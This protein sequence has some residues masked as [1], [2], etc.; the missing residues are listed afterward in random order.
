MAKNFVS[1][2]AVLVSTVNAVAPSGT[3]LNVMLGDPNNFGADKDECPLRAD[4]G[5][6]FQQDLTLTYSGTEA[7]DEDFKIYLPCIH[8]IL[9][10]SDD[11]VVENIVGDLTTITPPKDFKFAADSAVTLKLTVEYW[12]VVQTDNMPRWFVVS[13]GKAEV[14]ANTDSEDITDFSVPISSTMKTPGDLNV[15]MNAESRFDRNVGHFGTKEAQALLQDSRNRVVPKP[16]KT[17]VLSDVNVVLKTTTSDYAL[18]IV[19]A[20]KLKHLQSGAEYLLK[21][22]HVDLDGTHEVRLSIVASIEGDEAYEVEV[23]ADSTTVKASTEKGLFYGIMTILNLLEDGELPHVKITD[24][25]RFEYRGNHLDVGRNFYSKDAILKVLDAMAAY[26]LNK[27]H[28]GLTNDEAWRLQIPDLPELTD[29]GAKR[30]FEETEG[31]T[32]LIPT[33]GSGPTAIDAQYYTTSDYKEILK[34]A[35]ARNIEVIPEIDMPAHMRAAVISMES[36]FATT[37]DDTYRLLDPEDTTVLLTIQFYDRTSIM[38][39]CLNSSKAFTSKVMDEVL[40]MYDDAGIPLKKWHFG[41]D[42]AK[43]ILLGGG[44]AKFDPPGGKDKPFEKSPACAAEGV[45]YDYDKDSVANYWGQFV[46]D[47]LLAHGVNEMFAWED[48]VRGT[49]QGNYSTQVSIDFWEP[50]F[51]GS[52]NG[53]VQIAKDEFPLV[54]SCPDYLYFD[55]PYEVDVAERGYYWAG[56]ETSIHK[57]FA[58]A[59]QNLPQNAE[60]SVGRDGESME[61]DTPEDSTEPPVF[62]IQGQTWGET[63][64]TDEQMFYMMFPRL[65]A[66]AERA[67]H[68]AD[69]ELKWDNTKSFSQDTTHVDH[70]ALEADYQ[71]FIGAVSARGM[72]L[73]DEIQGSTGTGFRVPP[74]GAKVDGGKVHANSEHPGTPIQYKMAADEEW[75]NYDAPFAVPAGDNTI[76]FRTAIFGAG[77]RVTELMTEGGAEIKKGPTGPSRKPFEQQGGAWAILFILIIGMSVGTTAFCLLRAFKPDL[78]PAVMRPEAEAAQL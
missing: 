24:S 48:G 22:M 56:R 76:Q 29:I 42:E 45:D 16:D 77:S 60:T 58:F 14:I 71:D 6:C 33:L 73:L 37:G 54:L 75:M 57:V 12:N 9:E 49:N 64:R 34:Y 30:C 1:A 46:S 47:E 53:L 36:R 8:R 35:Y 15:P 3:N 31:E 13:D 74:P 17:Q 72:M 55:F 52:H 38:N 11:W 41:G 32:C 20:D 68:T 43:N 39:P 28:F 19:D 26:K 65:L 18:K 2:L 63:I 61:V 67:W 78:L 62:G 5:L 70:K 23:G 51:W 25:P 59:P 27:F 4:W 21:R 66:V 44:Y 69:W 50:L 10:I 7:T 40:K